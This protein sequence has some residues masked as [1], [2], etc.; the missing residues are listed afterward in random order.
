MCLVYYPAKGLKCHTYSRIHHLVMNNDIN[1]LEKYLDTREGFIQINIKNE[2][3]HTPL[4]LA[5]MNYMPDAINTLLFYGADINLFDIKGNSIL[6]LAVIYNKKPES[7]LLEFVSYLVT[8]LADTVGKNH[9]NQTLID[10]CYNYGY[11]RIMKYVLEYNK[12]ISRI[13]I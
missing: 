10:I 1:T 13:K 4:M 7:D 3:G 12:L 5:A 11:E 6:M 2:F 9:N 8:L